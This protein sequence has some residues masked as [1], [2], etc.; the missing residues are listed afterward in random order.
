MAVG[1]FRSSSPLMRHAIQALDVM[2]VW[3]AG[4]VCY[5]AYIG[6]Q[7]MAKHYLGLIFSTSLLMLMASSGVYRSWRGG[8]FR[9]ML[10]RVAMSWLGTWVMVLIWL[11]LSKTATD[12]SRVWLVSWAALTLGL[13]WVERFTVYFMLRWLRQKGYNHRSV[14]LVGDAPSQEN[15]RNRVAKSAWTGYQI[16]DS[17]TPDNLDRLAATVDSHSID[18]VW[19]S[20]QAQNIADIER[21]LYEL[22]Y[23]TANIRMVPDIFTYRLLNHGVSLVMGLPML[24]LSNTP[25]QGFSQVLKW[26]EDRVL[27]SLILVLISPLML[28]IAIGIKLTSTGPVFF[29]QQRHGWN[30]EV[31]QVLKFRTMVVH[32]EPAG[33]VIQATKGDDRVTPFGCILRRTS[34]DELPQF[35]NVVTG[36]MSIVGPRP[37]AIAHNEQYKELIPRYM[38]RHKVKP[39]ITGWAQ[40]NGLRGE[41]D[42]LDKMRMRVEYDMNYIEHW[43][44]WN[45]L[46]IISLTVFKGFVNHNAY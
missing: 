20:L 10:G 33:Q 31:I 21:V 3:L 28:A 7:P 43:S 46:K 40:I 37:H 13:L 36:T 6:Q 29:R 22:R 25:M 12:Y 17:V 16:V 35:I 38:L 27:G 44:L 24:D 26:L 19:I 39:G 45:D 14:V 30:G 15:I 32:Q 2:S 8:A 5:V 1:I 18:E 42:A 11:V 4:V 41:T 9:A 34:L 23:S